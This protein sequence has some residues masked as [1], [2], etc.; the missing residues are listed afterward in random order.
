L[1]Y[2]NKIYKENYLIVKNVAYKITADSD[3]TLDI[4][5]EVFLSYFNSLKSKTKINH[6]RT[7]LYRVTLNKCYDYI[8]S[9]HKITNV[10]LENIE[11]LSYTPANNDD[12]SR[13][14]H[15]ALSM[16]KPKEKLLIILYS[17][18]LSYKELSEV[19]EIKFTSIGQTLS[20]TLKKLKNELK[21]KEYELF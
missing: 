3:A 13:Y 6:P 5:Q 9:K 16:L 4:V 21:T 1:D 18:G 11:L 7:W 17:E 10:N 15:L 12:K 8:K 20:R 2:F 14:L 19:T